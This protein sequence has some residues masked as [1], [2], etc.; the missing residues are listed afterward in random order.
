MMELRL[1]FAKDFRRL[2]WLLAVWLIVVAGRVVL[3]SVSADVAFTTNLLQFALDN[4]SA[5]LGLVDVLLLLLLVSRLIHDEPLVG[6]D[7]FWLTRPIR[8]TMLMIT[9]LTFAA[10]WLVVA[11]V[12]VQSLVA[13]AVT[14]DVRETLMALPSAAAGQ[15]L[16]VVALVALA[17]VTPS[18]SRFLLTLVGTVAVLVVA[19]SATLTSRALELVEAPRDTMLPDDTTGVLVML[20]VLAMA[21]VVMTTQY[22]RRQLSR[23]IVVGAI[24][25]VVG[26][27]VISVW[28]WRFAKPAEPD[29]GAWTRD[30][31]AVAP[32]VDRNV[33]PYIAETYAYRRLPT[34]ARKQVAIPI[35][36]TGVP[37]NDTTTMSIRSRLVFSDGVTLES[38]QSGEVNVQPGQLE[39]ADDS[40][41]PLRAALAPAK[42][43]MRLPWRFASWPIVLIVSDADLARRGGE[44]G[45]LTL[46]MNVFLH[47]TRVIGS[48]PLSEGATTAL[49]SGPR[50]ELRHVV[51]SGGSCSVFIRRV[52]GDDD[53]RRHR[54]QFVLRNRQRSEFATG[55]VEPLGSRGLLLAGWALFAQTSGGGD[56]SDLMVSYPPRVAGAS[57][58]LDAEWL[59]GAD[60]AIVDTAYGGMFSRNMTIDGFRMKP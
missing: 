11:P 21:A 29:P 20:L 18:V 19:I 24:C 10:L 40:Q 7:A 44:P 4:I 36:I 13:A 60:I 2:R 48:L 6:A 30:T 56:F 57:T 28:P 47:E 1:I 31:S 15:L 46:A 55:D 54:Y 43:L 32:V 3:R 26:T 38:G 17:T 35:Q 58:P 59:R 50:F 34:S 53:S 25:A 9:K 39:D 33:T 23:S 12:L 37:P 16:W 14:H 42:P 49:Q 27:G 8:P 22:R 45:Q 5:L 52:G 51:A 41:A